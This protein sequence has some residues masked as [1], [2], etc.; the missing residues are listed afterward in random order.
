MATEISSVFGL[1]L[2]EWIEYA[3]VGASI[4]VSIAIGISIGVNVWLS[5]RSRE[6]IERHAEQTKEHAEQTHKIAS[7]NLVLDLKK[8]YH[9]YNFR[10]TADYLETAKERDPAKDN[11]VD[12]LLD[13]LEYIAVLWEDGVLTTHHVTQMFGSTFLLVKNND[14]AQGIIEEWNRQDP[15]FYYVYLKHLLG[16]LF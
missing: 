13:H 4:T 10:E 14:I 7:A 16:E 11:D 2:L 15:D 12:R 8:R 1:T 9:E 5:K 6:Q 3:A